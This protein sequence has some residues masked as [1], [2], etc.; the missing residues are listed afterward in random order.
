MLISLELCQGDY[1]ASQLATDI[2]SYTEEQLE[3][4]QSA[5][6]IENWKLKTYSWLLMQLVYRLANFSKQLHSQLASYCIL[7]T[8]ESYIAIMIIASLLATNN[9]HQQYIYI[10]TGSQLQLTNWNNIHTSMH[11]AMYGHMYMYC[12]MQCVHVAT[13]IAIVSL[14]AMYD[15]IVIT[16]HT[17]FIKIIQQLAS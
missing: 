17:S 16:L 14:L 13:H 11:V 12:N 5:C 9:L 8:K 10:Y 4:K 15:T 3:A 2:A 7:T 1:V 6:V